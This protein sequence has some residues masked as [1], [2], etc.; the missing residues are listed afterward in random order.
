M[1]HWICCNSCFVFPSNERRLAIT[2]CGHVVCNA[3][4][5]RSKPGECL[6]CN[7]SCQISPLS[8]KSCAEVKALFTDVGLT[9]KKYVTEINKVLMFQARHHKRLLTHYKQKSEKLEQ[10][11]QQMTKKMNEQSSYISKL[12]YSLQHQSAKTSSMPPMNFSGRTPRNS[13]LQPLSRHPSTHN[14]ME[15]VDGSSM[16]RKAS[17]LIQPIT[18]SRLSLISSPLLAQM[19]APHKASAAA[20]PHRP[21]SQNSLANTTRSATVS[22]CHGTPVTPGLCLDSFGRMSGW[23]SPIFN[24]STPHR[25]SP[26]SSL[27]SSNKRANCT[28]PWRLVL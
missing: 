23:E 21:L 11:M 27:A 3:C 24:P 25:R 14:I 16:F 22:S 17:P 12:E 13:V 9:A 8:N 26:M 1:A 2:S 15:I 4:H 19:G 6:I 7:T 28:G 5:Q 18:S 10:E 20:H